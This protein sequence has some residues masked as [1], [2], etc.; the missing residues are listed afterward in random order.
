MSL[1]TDLRVRLAADGAV[2]GLVAARIY[3]LVLPQKPTLPAIS[4][5]RIS[6][7]RIQNLL[8][9]TG[10]AVAR[11]QI[12]S[13]AETYVGAQ[14]LAAAV[15]S[16]LNGFIG[17]LTDGGSP[18]ATRGVVIRLDNERDNFEDELDLY[19]VIQDYLINHEE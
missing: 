15:R 17:D 10:R 14:T 18:A 5:Q 7:P 2:S 8:G 12:D 3:A 6:G 13:W 11:I 16:S 4:Y 1:E 9:A 19:R